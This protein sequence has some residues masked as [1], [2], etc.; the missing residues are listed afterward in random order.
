MVELKTRDLLNMI[1]VSEKEFQQYRE[2]LAPNERFSDARLSDLGLKNMIYQAWCVIERPKTMQ[3]GF[4]SWRHFMGFEENEVAYK[5]AE[6]IGTKKDDLA[7][8]ARGKAS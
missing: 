3:L 7:K 1:F 6:Y 2:K 5:A 8:L 4:E